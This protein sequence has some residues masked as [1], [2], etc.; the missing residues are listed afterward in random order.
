MDVVTFAGEE[1]VPISQEF[2]DK[3]VRELER[4]RKA[5]YLGVADAL[6]WCN[7]N[8]GT[9]TL[10]EGLRACTPQE[11]Y[12]LSSTCTSIWSMAHNI[13]Y[14]ARDRLLSR[15]KLADAELA[16]VVVDPILPGGGDPNAS[17]HH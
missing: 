1:Y 15:K 16:R 13:L 14:M 3:L 11:L 8:K 2:Y 7:A 5:R 12:Q 17:D 4:N 6:V 10:Q 9:S